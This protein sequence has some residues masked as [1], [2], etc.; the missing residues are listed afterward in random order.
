MLTFVNDEDTD[1]IYKVNRVLG[2]T[3]KIDQVKVSKF[4]LTFGFTPKFCAKEPRC[5]KCAGRHITSDC[6][7]T[8]D[9]KSKCVNCGEEHHA[10]YRGCLGAKELQKFKNK[11]DYKVK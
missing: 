5:V 4:I 9:Q 6:Q 11:N 7:Q 8:E 1:K 2:N 10:N 3:V